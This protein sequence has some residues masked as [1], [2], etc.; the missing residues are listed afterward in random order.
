MN[1][2]RLSDV[3]SQRT[4]SLSATTPRRRGDWGA[5]RKQREW[6]WWSWLGRMRSWTE[7]ETVLAHRLSGHNRKMREQSCLQFFT[8]TFLE[9]S[10]KCKKN[11]QKHKNITRDH[12]NYFLNAIVNTFVIKLAV[13]SIMIYVFN[14]LFYRI[15]DCNRGS[16]VKAKYMRLVIT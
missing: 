14:L 3:Y 15:V 8:G 13:R 11:I 7:T 12:K 4:E 6:G 16:M 10:I 2:L 9:T 1:I 5:R